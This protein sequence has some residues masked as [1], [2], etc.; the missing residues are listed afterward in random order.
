MYNNVTITDEEGNEYILN[1]FQLL[2]AVLDSRI[3]IFTMPFTKDNYKTLLYTDY[4]YRVRLDYGWTCMV[5]Y[6]N[7]NI[8]NSLVLAVEEFLRYKKISLERRYDNIGGIEGI[9]KEQVVE[10]YYKMKENLL[11]K[12]LPYKKAVSEK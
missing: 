3:A 10:Y 8:I 5:Y 2:H 6:N 12:L 7:I 9:S 4:N 1:Y 11:D